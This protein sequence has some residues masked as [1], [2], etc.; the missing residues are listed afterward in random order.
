MEKLLLGIGRTII[1]PEVGGNLYGYYPNIYSETVAD[2][3]TAD[4][5]Y[6]RQGDTCALMVSATVCAIAEDTCDFLRAQIQEKFGIP[7]EHCMLSAIHT[8]SGPCLTGGTGWGG[9]DVAYVENIFIPGVLKAVEA[10]VA[11]PEPVTMGV[12]EGDSLVGINRRQLTLENRIILGQ[13]PWGSFN[14]RMT[15]LS[16]KNEAGNVVGAMVHYGCH[17][18][19]A[20]HNHEISRDWPGVMIDS[21][22]AETGGIVSFFN[23]PEGDIGPRLTN[24]KTIGNDSMDYVYELGAVA[25]ADAKRV[26]SQISEYTTPELKAG[27]GRC[28]IPLRPRISR[29]EAEAMYE[30]YKDRT[31][32]MTALMKATAK[33]VMD[34]W[35]ADAPQKESHGFDQVIISLGDSVF[36]A[37]PYEL[38][39][40]IGMRIDGGVPGKR[41][42][43]VINT[44]GSQAYFVTQDAICRGGYEISQFLY[45]NLQAYCENADF[46]LILATLENLKVVCPDEEAK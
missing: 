22:E 43:P 30:K 31:V 2:D 10:A 24:G 7:A 33:R 20:G 6:F 28:E 38:F 41:I 21:L 23:G 36:T 44:N 15:V 5:W 32:N 14:P 4:A 12:S 46:A 39:S 34:A 25:A 35:D 17:A 29:E 42:L 26:Y 11:D 8:H 3:L 45:R 13:N 1:T 40:E 16:F 9:R 27:W 18:T 19:A 37:F